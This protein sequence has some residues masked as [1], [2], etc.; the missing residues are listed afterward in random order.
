MEI[1]G[2][3]R[4]LPGLI[5]ASVASGSLRSVDF[6]LL[7]KKVCMIHD[8]SRSIGHK[9]EYIAG[10]KGCAAPVPEPLLAT[11]IILPVGLLP[12]RCSILIPNTQLRGNIHIPFETSALQVSQ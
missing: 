2:Q 4:G 12:F 11:G 8:S 3:H 6:S 9:S 5:V 10:Q 1:L 7:Y